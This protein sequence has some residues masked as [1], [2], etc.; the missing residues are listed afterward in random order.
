MD[1]FS[2]VA[3]KAQGNA[4]RTKVSVGKAKKFKKRRFV[5]AIEASS[6][7]TEFENASAT[8]EV[9]TIWGLKEQSIIRYFKI[10]VEIC[11]AFHQLVTGPQ[12]L[13]S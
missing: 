4:A 1:Y 13:Q 7:N 2:P 3:A 11:T 10:L 8:S 5:E 9:S 12:S 6:A